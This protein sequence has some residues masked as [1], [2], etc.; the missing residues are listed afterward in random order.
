MIGST[1]AAAVS[2]ALTLGALACAVLALLTSSRAPDLWDACERTGGTELRYM[3]QGVHV[4]LRGHLALWVYA[5]EN[6]P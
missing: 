5:P 3:G 4:C 2:Y 1:V 6:V